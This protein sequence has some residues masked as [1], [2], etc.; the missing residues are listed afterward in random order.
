MG[1]KDKKLEEMLIKQMAVSQPVSDKVV[2]TLKHP[3]YTSGKLIKYGDIIL[4]VLES[5]ADDPTKVYVRLLPETSI[6]GYDYHPTALLYPKEKVDLE[7]ITPELSRDLDDGFAKFTLSLVIFNSDD[8]DE[9]CK[10]YWYAGGTEKAIH[11]I[12]QQEI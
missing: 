3:R 12:K 8:I 6:P 7:N 5:K 10:E 2:K 4:H 11:V 9:I 1:Q